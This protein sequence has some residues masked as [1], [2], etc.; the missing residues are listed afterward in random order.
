ML[1][2][3]KN[4][5]KCKQSKNKSGAAFLHPQS[6]Y[7]IVLIV[8]KCSEKSENMDELKQKLDDKVYGVLKSK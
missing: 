7:F 4:K 6:N 5:K 3:E 1:G 2:Q 8:K